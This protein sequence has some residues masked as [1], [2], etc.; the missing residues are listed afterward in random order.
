MNA[1][2]RA[3]AERAGPLLAGQEIT[4]I[5]ASPLQRARQT[6]EIINE[7]LRL[8]LSIEPDLREVAF[9]SME[10]EPLLPWFPDWLEGRATPDGRRA[11]LRSP[12][13]SRRY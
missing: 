8:P 12:G 7:F 5:I 6:A 4:A 10:G 13:A 3:Q 11:S 1:T 9:G 2:G